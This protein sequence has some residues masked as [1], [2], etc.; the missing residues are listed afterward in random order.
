MTVHIDRSLRLPPSEYFRGTGRP[1]D[2]S[3]RSHEIR[4]V[5]RRQRAK[6]RRHRTNVRRQQPDVRRQRTN[7]R[8]HRPGVCGP[9]TDVRRQRANVR[10]QQA[11][12]RRHR[13][14]VRGHHGDVRGPTPLVVGPVGAPGA[15]ASL[16]R[17]G[18]YTEAVSQNRVRHRHA[19]GAGDRETH[20][21][22][23]G[24]PHAAGPCGSAPRRAKASPPERT[25]TVSATPES[26]TP[27]PSPHPTAI[28]TLLM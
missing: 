8:V 6:V 16:S 23:G 1:A 26:R 7:V 12:V 15:L 28:T 21:C 10:R 20:A 5:V 27:M 14:N 11:N 22:G 2:R 17:G 25:L 3:R 24:F 13:T 9:W 4:T 19:R 18:W